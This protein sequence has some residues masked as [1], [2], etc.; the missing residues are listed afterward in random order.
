[1]NNAE[2]TLTDCKTQQLLSLGRPRS[3][4]GALIRVAY[5][6]A[7]AGP[8]SSSSWIESLDSPTGR[9]KYRESEVFGSFASASLT[10]PPVAGLFRQNWLHQSPLPAVRAIYKIHLSQGLLEPYLR[11][12]FASR[13]CAKCMMVLITTTQAND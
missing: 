13:S 10:C 2:N 12:R 8:S 9:T 5:T 1:M 6:H 11:H 7:Y 3:N 4:H